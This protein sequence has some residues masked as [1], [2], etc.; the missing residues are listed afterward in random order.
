VN[1]HL[2]HPLPLFSLSLSLSLT[3]TAVVLYLFKFLSQHL[4]GTHTN[5]IKLQYI[6]L[7]SE[8]RNLRSTPTNK[9]YESDEKG[10][11]YNVLY[12][13]HD[14]ANTAF[15]PMQITNKSCIT[16]T[17]KQNCPFFLQIW[18][19]LLS[20]S[21]KDMNN[22]IYAVKKYPSSEKCLLAVRPACP[23]VSA[24]Y[25]AYIIRRDDYANCTFSRQRL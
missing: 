12:P 22:D 18:L 13:I 7:I 4:S 9:E 19:L 5:F 14:W 21:R 11:V 1:I 23:T 6:H 10:W 16:T 3:Q 2:H 15:F 17:H 8:D 24:E 20:K 25:S